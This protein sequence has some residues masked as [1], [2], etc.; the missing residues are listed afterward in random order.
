MSDPTPLLPPRVREL[1]E[2]KAIGDRSFVLALQAVI[3]E[4]D[5]AG[6]TRITRPGGS[7]LMRYVH[8]CRSRSSRVSRQRDL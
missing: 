5:D 7:A 3:R 4:A 8:T 1:V 6:V 2:Q